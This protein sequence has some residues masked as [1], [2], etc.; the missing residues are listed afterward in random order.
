VRRVTQLG[1]IQSLRTA[2]KLADFTP[3]S[4]QTAYIHWRRL[5]YAHYT[6]RMAAS[7]PGIRI[8]LA[9]GVP[10]AGREAAP[11]QPTPYSPGAVSSTATS[12]RSGA[13]LLTWSAIG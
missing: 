1:K 2:P 9:K 7:G 4:L 12:A 13:F 3:C 10:R 8:L 5:L 6:L 11:L